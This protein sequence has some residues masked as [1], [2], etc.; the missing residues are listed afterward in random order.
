MGPFP[1]ASSRTCR[2]GFPRNIGEALSAV[3]TPASDYR[4]RVGAAVRPDVAGRCRGV[5]VGRPHVAT[6]AEAGM[7]TAAD[8]LAGDEDP[9]PGRR[10]V[11]RT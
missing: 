8:L 9:R 1:T 3:A 2:A 4:G 6:W 7:V 11:D 5:R 10:V